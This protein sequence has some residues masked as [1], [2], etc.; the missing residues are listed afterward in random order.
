MAIFWMASALRENC[1]AER[2]SLTP[3]NTSTTL[4]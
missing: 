3:S 2:L 4:S 1:K